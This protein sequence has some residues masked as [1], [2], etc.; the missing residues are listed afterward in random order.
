MPE[1][2]LAMD[3]GTESLRAA[4][5]D[6]E[7]N[8]LGDFAAPYETDFPQPKWAEQDPGQWWQSAGEACKKALE[9]AGA[10]KE[11]VA[12][13]CAD[14]TCCTVVFA[15]K[16]GT[17]LR[18]CQLW[19]DVRAEA[20]AQKVLETGD[21]AL[22]VNNA[23]SGPVS[24]EW[25]VP[26]ALWIKEND[27]GTYDKAAVVCE[28]Q[29]WLNFKMT[30][31]WAAS[32]NNV[33]ARW[34]YS[35]RHG[36][37]PTGMLEALSM[38]DLQEKWP[39][40]V[41]AL[42]EV[43]GELT[44]DAAAHMGLA[45]G[46]PVVQGGADALIGIVGLGVVEPGDLTLITGSSHL[47]FLVC[48]NEYH[49]KGVWGTFADHVY[50]GKHILEGGQTSTGSVINW[51]RRNFAAD[52]PYD[53]LDAEAAKIEPGCEGLLSQD[54]FQGCRAPH[55]DPLSAGALV[56]LSLSHSRAHV[57]RAIIEGV[58]L[59]TK[60]I[61]EGF[62]AA[63]KIERVVAA[64]GATN[65]GLWMQIHADTLGMDIERTV[66]P[67]APLLGD[68]I[69]AATGVGKF[70]RI[71]DGCKAMVQPLPEATVRCDRE[72]AQR[73]DEVFERY[74][75]LYQALRPFSAKG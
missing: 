42:G 27:P 39:Q 19:M 20:Q 67:D 37:W 48:D 5:F 32:L 4:V 54:H 66:V 31:R 16:D 71:E 70:D 33:S 6:L 63:G 2:V 64:G 45:A 11:D 13:V 17:P 41:L 38:P 40:D 30:G 73:Y 14:T 28:Y 52:V 35:S 25:M 69:L 53:V 57:Y 56:G 51:F 61:L 24:A 8:K 68:A 72:Q 43:V 65:S 58:C 23:G 18:P 3:G 9:A 44:A 36:G 74:K 21:G 29:D 59:G 55:T 50:P 15:D 26:K 46:T 7:G 62:K 34:H 49:A 12:A 75:G 47:L 60:L 22:R 10:K 1:L